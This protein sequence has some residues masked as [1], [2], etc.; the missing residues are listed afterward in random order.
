MARTK[1]SFLCRQ[2]SRIAAAASGTEKSITT[3]TGTR[4]SDAKGTPKV[5]AP[6]MR[7]A[8]SPKQRVARRFQGRGDGQLRVGRAQG[9]QA[10]A[11]AA[12]RTVNGNASHRR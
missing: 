5:P 3:L 1:G 7:P 10:A 2:V 9:D 4:S 12:G 8:S 11:H 6:A